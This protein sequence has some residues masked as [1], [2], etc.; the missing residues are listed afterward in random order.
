[1]KKMTSTEI[2]RHFLQFFEDKNHK[3]VPSAPIVQKDDPTLLFTNAGMNQ[4]KD[5]FLGDATPDNPRLVDT[6]KCLRVSGKHNDLEEVGIDSYH[7][8]MF[9]MLGNWSV[10]DYFKQEAIDWAWELLTEVYELPKDRLYASVF[11]GDQSESLARDEEAADFWKKWLP[12]EQIL[13]FDK[14]DNFWEM[15]DTGPCGPCSEIHV[16]LRS[17][18]DRKAKNGRDLVNADHP[19]VVEIWNLVFIQYN[20]KADGSLQELPAKHID[21]GMGFERLTMALQGKTSSYDTDIFSPFIKKIEEISGRSYT[22]SYDSRAKSDIAMRVASDHIRAVAFAIA[23]GELPSNTGAGYVIRRI[24][25]RAV[26]YY[27]SFL[28]IEEPMLHRLI[29]MLADY[30]AEVFPELKAQEDFVKKVIL[31]EEKSFLR[32]LESGLNRFEIIEVNEGIID[33]E[34]AFELYDTYGFPIDLTRLLASEKGL[35]VDEEAFETALQAQKDRSRSAATKQVGDWTVLLKDSQV[36]FVGYDEEEVEDVKVIKYRTVESKKGKAYQIVLNKTPFYAE[37]G[38]QVG[39][40]GK[41]D[42]GGTSI[43][44]LDTTKENDLGI[45]IVNRLP[46]NINAPITATIDQKKRALTENNHSATHLLHAALREVLGNHVQQKGS[47]NNERYLR[48]DFLHFQKM[49]DEEI[50]RVEQMVN[51]KI[52]ANIQRGEQRNVPIEAAK[53]SGATMLFG[54]KYGEE[55]RMITFD[56]DFSLELCGGC[57]VESTGEIGYFKILSESAIAAGVR[58]IEAVTA[59]AAEQYLN[60]ALAELNEVRLLFKNPIDVVKSVTDLQEENKQLQKQIEQMLAAQASNVKSELKSAFREVN[61]VNILIQQVT[62]E[63]SKALKNLAYQLEKEVGDAVI[64]FGAIIN[65]KPQLM[66]AISENLTKEKGMNAGKIVRNI[67]KHIK[68]GGGGQAFF[69]TAGG[70]D[71]NGL[72]AALEAAKSEIESAV[73]A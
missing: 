33:G 54:E 50:Q 8:T 71:V 69:A 26:R 4:F 24:L 1:M 43:K 53:K 9:E 30:F 25:R 55:V 6:Q 40:T 59:E 15:G 12:A 31:E 39:D 16:D 70:K 27:Y 46:E 47:L 67:A 3:I 28:D 42:F 52:R 51:E 22:S 56:K 48:F 60:T 32:T 13:Y 73:S 65:D 35:K 45:H 63:D 49:T 57:H 10:G 11:E 44:V 29:P 5:Y 62:L 20:R 34:A 64:I 58:R 7:H 17:E 66:A 37:S 68:G 41:L 23:D 18:A 19:E 36:E 21:T 72:A 2:R 38:G 61:G 14:K